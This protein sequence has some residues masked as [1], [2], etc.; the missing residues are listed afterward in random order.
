MIMPDNFN[1]SISF[2]RARFLESN[3]LFKDNNTFPSRII[4]QYELV[5]FLSDGG[6]SIINGAKYSISKGA[7]RLLKP[8]DI[9]QSYRFSDIY[10]VHFDT[11]SSNLLDN[12]SSFT[13]TLD[14]NLSVEM[15]RKI[16]E[17]FAEENIIKSTYNLLKVLNLLQKNTDKTICTDKNLLSIKNY[18]DCNYKNKITLSILAELHYI[19]PVHLQKKFKKTFGITPSEYIKSLRINEAKKLLLTS[20]L[21]V[22]SIGES[23]GFCNTSYFI[24]TFC[25]DVKMTPSKYRSSSIEKYDY[26]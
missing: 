24:K 8:D 26:I 5:L 10:T 19:H 18:I 4:T 1:F 2:N 16:C 23:L 14:Y 3:T 12:I 7:I 17:G 15:F 11:A 6:Y 13:Y 21:S 9:V 25:D 22:E 20:N